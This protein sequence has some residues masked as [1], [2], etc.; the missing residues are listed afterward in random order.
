MSETVVARPFGFD[1]TEHDPG[2]W[3]ASLLYNAELV[4]DVLA[5]AGGTSITPV[6]SSCGRSEAVGA[7]SPSTPRPARRSRRSPT[8][9]R[10]CGSCASPVSR[11]S[12]RSP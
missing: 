3:G 1:P 4:M 10:A 9:M 7:S 2:S 6:C 12:P 8:P 5:A 11:R